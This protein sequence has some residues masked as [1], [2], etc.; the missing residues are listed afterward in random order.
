MMIMPA[1]LRSRHHQEGGTTLLLVLMSTTLLSI[2]FGTYMITLGH[3]RKVEEQR[4]LDDRAFMAAEAGLASEIVRLTTLA[5]PPTSNQTRT[6]TF[7]ASQDYSPFQVTAATSVQ[8]KNA[9]GYWTVSATATADPALT[10]GQPFSRRVQATLVQE[11]F[12]KYEMFTNDFGGVWSPGYLQF[13]G[14]GTVYMGPVNIN[15][16]AAIFPNFW[17]M[18]EVTTAAP[19]GVRQF[20][21]AGDYINGVY[22]QSDANDYLNLLTYWSSTYAQNPQ[23]YGGLRVLPESIPLPQDMNNDSRAEKLRAN[24]G[25][26]LPADYPGYVAD[27]GPNFVVDLANAGGSGNGLITVRQY[28]G[29]VSGVP[30]YGA[31]LV[32]TVNGVNG[33]MVV[34]GNVASLQGTLDGRLTIGVFKDGAHPDAGNVDVTGSLQYESRVAQNNFKYTDAPEVFTADKSG[35]NKNY[36]N[37]LQ[38]QLDNVN[39]MLGIVSEG[40]VMIKEK[41]LNGQPIANQA[42]VPMYVDAVVMATGT[43]ASATSTGGFGVENFL[44]RPPGKVYFLGGMIQNRSLSWAL[45]NDSGITNG[46][47]CAQLW[48]QRSA[49]AG[50]APPF[51]P[52]T[53]NFQVLANSW[54]TA[55]VAGASTPVVLPTLP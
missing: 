50:G 8:A 10:R 34:K 20:N 17:S 41:D 43:S 12:A 1:S 9:Q 3:Y 24:A 52:S 29:N 27:A 14:L 54:L 13:L 40:D 7:P 5:T 18:S 15:S 49:Q 44:T 32:K 45:F 11:N 37:T 26:N 48:D 51:F 23:F 46:L 33:A 16:G 31:P 38:G 35:I 28:L 30:T 42:S 36:I 22:G 53:G 47:D 25:L 21:N 39:D 4:V 19:K 2:A 6:V 55:Y